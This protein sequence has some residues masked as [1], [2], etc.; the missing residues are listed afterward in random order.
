MLSFFAA[1]I[2]SFL[3]MTS[4]SLSSASFTSGGG[5][6]IIPVAAGYRQQHGQ[7]YQWSQDVSSH[8]LLVL[9]FSPKLEKNIISRKFT[10]LHHAAQRECDASGFANDFEYNVS[11]TNYFTQ[12]QRLRRTDVTI[13]SKS[14]Y[15]LRV[16]PP[17][18][19]PT[20]GRTCLRIR[21]TNPL[22]EVVL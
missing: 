13:S 1:S 7:C 10:A 8:H 19:S 4:S 11:S 9:V 18:S 22:K 3:P 6:N 16:T 12:Y 20:Y 14:L 2:S 21:S 5:E 15:L 17:K